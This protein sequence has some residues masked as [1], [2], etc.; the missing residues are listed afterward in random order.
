MYD[1]TRQAKVLSSEYGIVH[2]Q[3]ASADWSA[4]RMI[5][6]EHFS[7]YPQ[8]SGS[9]RMEVSEMGYLILGG[10]MIDLRGLQQLMTDG[11]RQAVGF[12]L[13]YLM[14]REKEEVFSLSE[15]LDA[16]MTKLERDGL[17]S[18]YSAYFTSCGRFF[19]LPRKHDVMAV[20]HRMRHLTYQA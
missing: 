14:T 1:V 10:E 3:P 16:L 7:S 20:V 13:R 19:D 4:E 8:G 17:D 15:R 2:E 5:L 6:K 11:Q 12:L 9:E 18:I